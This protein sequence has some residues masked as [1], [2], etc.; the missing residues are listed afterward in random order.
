ML[1]KWATVLPQSHFAESDVACSKIWLKP[2]ALLCTCSS[3]VVVFVR[4]VG[5]AAGTIGLD[6]CLY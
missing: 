5:E 2:L 1:R 4:A 6:S 3:T